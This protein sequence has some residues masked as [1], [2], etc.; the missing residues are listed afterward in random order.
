MPVASYWPLLPTIIHATGSG[1]AP[2]LSEDDFLA[3]SQD[4]LPPGPAWPRDL[5]AML[6]QMLRGLAVS[7]ARGHA[8]QVAL[9]ADLNPA[10]T[11][12]LLPEW[13]AS[14]G[15]P[16]PCSGPGATIGARRAQ[17][18]ARLRA[19]DGQ[20]ISYYVQVATDLGYTVEIAELS[21]G[22]CDETACNEPWGAP[23]APL[24]YREFAMDSLVTEPLVEW[25]GLHPGTDWDYALRITAVKPYSSEWAVGDS[26][27][28]DSLGDYT[29]DPLTQIVEF[30]VGDSD[31]NVPLDAWGIAV[32]ECELTRILPAQA[33]PIFAY[34]PD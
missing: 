18:L 4:L 8:R 12:E 10:T 28:D 32:L 20:R 14:L 7:P 11:V 34:A 24:P 6:T 30:A 33:T 1:L 22:R 15:L 23:V 19:D 26:G 29:G 9:L 13:E 3:L 21:N 16:D 17:V 25:T 5:D 2:D 31:V 27:N